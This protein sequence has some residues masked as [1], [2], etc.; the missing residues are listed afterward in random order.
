MAVSSSPAEARAR[1]ALLVAG[2]ASVL[3]IG[4]AGTLSR[5]AGGVLLVVGWL[6]FVYALHAFGRAGSDRD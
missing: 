3:G 4:L 5:T 1:T 2:G 6:A